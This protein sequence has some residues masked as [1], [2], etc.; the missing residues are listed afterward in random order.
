MP[1]LSQVLGVGHGVQA[2][3]PRGGR[4]A[5][6]EHS[7]HS[8][9]TPEFSRGSWQM[10]SSARATGPPPSWCG[11]LPLSAHGATAARTTGSEQVGSCSNTAAP[12]SPG[13]RPQRVGQALSTRESTAPAGAYYLLECSSVKEQPPE[14]PG[15]G[16]PQA[17]LGS[18]R[19]SRPVDVGH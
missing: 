1:T 13:Q 9:L 6:A 5:R 2:L 14:L 3:H 12:G 16:K 7:P 19:C 11:P 18:L 4:M 15:G 17:G 8:C 10:A